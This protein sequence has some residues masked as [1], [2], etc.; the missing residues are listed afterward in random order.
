MDA[1]DGMT[2]QAQPAPGQPPRP[3]LNLKRRKALAAKAAKEAAEAAAAAKRRPVAVLPLVTAGVLC[4]VFIGT[5]G[6]LIFFSAEQSAP[7]PAAPAKTADQIVE[8]DNRWA[9]RPGVLP[10]GERTGQAGAE[11]SGLKAG[12]REVRTG[13]VQINLRTVERP[14]VSG[15][16]SPASEA[17]SYPAAPRPRPVAGETGGQEPAR[18]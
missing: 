11:G 9:E 8:R 2:P 6:V 18:E 1:P 10:S 7:K 15:A 5:I 4:L 14:A 16:P 3:V 17:G 12:H 13:T